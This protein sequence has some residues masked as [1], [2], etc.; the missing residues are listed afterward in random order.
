MGET[1][2]SE[3]GYSLHVDR[4]VADII[5]YLNLSIVVNGLAY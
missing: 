1:L 2:C 3:C 5:I 4:K